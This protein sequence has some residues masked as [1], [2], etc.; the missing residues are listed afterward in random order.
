MFNLGDARNGSGRPVM[1]T[2]GVREIENAV[3]AYRD[4]LDYEILDDAP[5]CEE[6]AAVLGN[7]NAAG[8]ASYI[9]KPKSDAPVFIRLIECDGDNET[10]AAPLHTWFAIELTVKDSAGLFEKFTAGEYFKPYAPP[11]ALPFTDKIFPFQ[12][13]GKNGE[14]LYLNEI[15]GSMDDVDLPLAASFV[16]HIFIVILNASS[17]AASSDFYNSLLV[18]QIK[19]EHEIPYKTINRVFDL[20]LETKHRL[21]TLGQGRSV[22]LEVDQAP[23]VKLEAK[24]TA[25]IERGLLC[26]SFMN[27]EPLAVN[28][29]SVMVQRAPYNGCAVSQ[30]LGPDGERIE[31]ISYGKR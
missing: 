22:F 27:F 2:I 18:T 24:P 17:L 20:P 13:R 23:N 10:D 30:I 6:Y 16:D 8:R 9:L 21:N 19:E 7:L 14:I 5:I 31:L 28:Q 26:I 29:D 3:S 15:R 1:A 4:E 12:C 11:K 25:I